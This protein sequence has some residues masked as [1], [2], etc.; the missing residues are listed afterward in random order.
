[1][2]AHRQILQRTHEDELHS[3]TKR[4]RMQMDDMQELYAALTNAKG[5]VEADLLL[6]QQENQSLR[7][8]RRKCAV[9][10]KRKQSLTCPS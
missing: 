2:N 10:R 9:Y 5:K 8:R 7:V 4:L 3:V 6:A 1:M